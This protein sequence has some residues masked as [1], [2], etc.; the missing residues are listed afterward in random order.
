MLWA[1]LGTV[2]LALIL[3]FLYKANLGTAV[4]SLG[5]WIA[6]GGIHG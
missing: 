1:L 4:E 6:N 3:L 2:L 5:L